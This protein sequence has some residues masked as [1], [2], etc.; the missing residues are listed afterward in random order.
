[1]VLSCFRSLSPTSIFLPDREEERRKERE[2]RQGKG[3][4]VR[5]KTMLGSSLHS[6]GIY[7]PSPST[8]YLNLA[9]K[10]RKTDRFPVEVSFLLKKNESLHI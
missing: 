1:V 8:H 10:W 9:R 2:N 5:D 7:H 3:R 4:K 6:A